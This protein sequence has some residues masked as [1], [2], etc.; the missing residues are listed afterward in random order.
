MALDDPQL[1]AL[2]LVAALDELPDVCSI[3][4]EDGL[5]MTINPANERLI[6]VPREHVIGRFN[7][8]A[9]ERVLGPE[10]LAAY[11]RAFAGAVQVMPV[12]RIQIEPPKDL[13]VQ[14]LSPVLF[15]ETTLVPL[16]RRPDGRAPYVLGLSRD[17]TTAMKA[18]LEIEQQRATIAALEAAHREIEAQRATIE[19]LSTPVIEVWDGVVTLPLLGRLDATRLAGATARLLD[20]VTRLRARVVILDVTGLA[21]LDPDVAAGLLRMLRAAELLGARGVLVGIRPDVAGS[22]ADLDVGLGRVT[23]RQNLRQALAS[24]LPDRPR[25][26]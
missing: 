6:G 15:L 21:G 10:R 8:F 14:L 22:L 16:C 23:V 2:G 17:V 1:A 3:Y 24:C 11:R 25:A 26:R 20:A 7:L 13:D 4:R 9:D 5:L 19:A 18:N 12:T